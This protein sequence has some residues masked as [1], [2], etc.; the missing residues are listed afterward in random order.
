MGPKARSLSFILF[1]S[2][3]SVELIAHDLDFA[4]LLFPGSCPLLL[5]DLFPFSVP[6]AVIVA[7]WIP[8]GA[9]QARGQYL[10]KSHSNTTL[11][12]WSAFRALNV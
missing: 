4:L 2:S 7:G 8:I 6:V 11:I 1:Q 12:L 10:L 5:V 9:V 3:E